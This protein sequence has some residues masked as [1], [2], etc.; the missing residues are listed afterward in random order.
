MRLLIA[1]LGLAAALAAAPIAI[2]DVTGVYKSRFNNGLVDGTTYKSEDV[3]EIVK[4]SPRQAYVRAHLEFYNGHVCDISGVAQLENGALVY[5][6][7]ENL[8]KDKCELTLQRKGDKIVF[9]DKNFACKDMYC[10][11]RGSFNDESFPMSSR[12][13]IRYMPRLRAS[14]QYAAAMRE[15][16]L[17]VPPPKDYKRHRDND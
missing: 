4:V 9:G 13:S 8:G 5:R 3:L 6:P 7:H 14:S 11:A 15:Q 17:A 12:R 10:G 2:D 1:A 16:G